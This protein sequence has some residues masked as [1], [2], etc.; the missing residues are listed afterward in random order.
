MGFNFVQMDPQQCCSHLYYVSGKDAADLLN[1][2]S[3]V[4]IASLEPLKPHL[5]FFLEPTG[6]IK[7][8]FNLLT[9]D[10]QTPLPNY[11]PGLPKQGF[12]IE[13]RSFQAQSRF[14]QNSNVACVSS[15]NPFNLPEHLSYFTFTEEILV[16][17]ISNSDQKYLCT[18][19]QMKGADAMGILQ[20]G[21]R[22]LD[23]P[24]WIFSYPAGSLLNSEL[25]TESGLFSIWTPADNISKLNGWLKS[26]GVLETKFDLFEFERIQNGI[27]FWGSRPEISGEFSSKFNPI[28]IGL[29]HLVEK[30]KGC[31]P[32]QEV[33]EKIVTSG[34]THRGLARFKITDYQKF[35]PSP[36]TENLPTHS[37]NTV[38]S[39]LPKEV[40][41]LTSLS[42]DSVSGSL[43]IQNP[44]ALGVI[45][46]SYLQPTLTS[47]RLWIESSSPNGESQNVTHYLQPIAGNSNPELRSAK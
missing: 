42:T 1:R 15:E 21:L 30:P 36:S 7:G 4:P 9:L 26:I 17:E 31:Y 6:R 24:P 35:T 13:S 8:A 37:E 46:K 12:L 19:A 22:S 45:R 39:E 10:S 41:T 29:L 32:G 5:G 23:L 40:G 20:N 16:T 47:T 44:L 25:S 43:N 3:T 28:E 11:L 18:F 38:F 27:P 14:L 34:K 33:I 2:L